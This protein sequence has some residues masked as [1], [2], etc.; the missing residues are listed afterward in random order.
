[1]R[2]HQLVGNNETE[3]KGAFLTLGDPGALEMNVGDSPYGPTYPW[4][5]RCC[6][7]PLP[8][9]GGYFLNELTFGLSDFPT[10]GKASALAGTLHV[11]H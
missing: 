1:M 4:L 3:H 10:P 2:S 5:R 7:P 6:S 9:E 8:G 11:V